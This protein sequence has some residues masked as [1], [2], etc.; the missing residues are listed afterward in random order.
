MYVFILKY[1]QRLYIFTPVKRLLKGE[2]M[3]QKIALV[4]SGGGALGAF[5]FG[6]IKYIEEIY[7]KEN[8]GFDYSIIA[9]ISVGSLNAVM[10][11]MD[12]YH[13]LKQVWE[14]ISYKEVFL[15]KINFLS[16]IKV[17][18]GANYFASNKPLYK[19]IKKNT[20]LKNIKPGV[21]LRF[22]LVSL[23]DGEYKSLK[24]E[25]FSDNVNFRK[26]VLASTTIPVINKPVKSIKLKS[27][28]EIKQLVDGGVRRVSP[29]KDALELDPDILIMINCT[30]RVNKIKK[31]IGDIFNIARVVVTQINMNENINSSLDEFI[32]TNNLVKQAKEQGVR[33]KKSDGSE[34]KVYDYLI[35]EPD[36]N[37]GDIMDFSPETAQYRIEKGYKCAEKQFENFQI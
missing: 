30:P 37:I 25:N 19:K 11:A 2:G 34:Y 31:Q 26:A 15:N 27:G 8:P 32:K 28:V 24:P 9:G 36:E 18:F 10:L 4:L 14:N 23:Y 13:E 3:S 22:G 21:D 29:I 1:T 12:K 35:I 6:A 16:A 17:L 20:F 7:K 33:L 5:Q